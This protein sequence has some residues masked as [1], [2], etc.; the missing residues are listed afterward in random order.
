M[1][2]VASEGKQLYTTPKLERYGDVRDLTM[3][4]STHGG[5]DGG[6]VSPHVKTH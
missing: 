4:V 3:S 1:D 6:A 5:N 2:T